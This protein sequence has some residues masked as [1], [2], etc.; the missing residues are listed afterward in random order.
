MVTFFVVVFAVLVIGLTGWTI[1][2][3]V[4]KDDS[5]PLIKEELGN[6]LEITKMLFVSIRSLV[7]LLR[8]ASF[9][10]ISDEST[11]IDDQLLKFVPKTSE[12]QED[13]KVA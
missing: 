3:Y 5:Q 7:Q 11:E 10:S 8:K 13:N 2:T 6:M 4:S 12:K 1:T 9:H